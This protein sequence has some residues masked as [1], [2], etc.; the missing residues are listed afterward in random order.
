MFNNLGNMK[1]HTKLHIREAM[2]EQLDFETTVDKPA[3]IYADT[4]G[5]KDIF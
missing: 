1:S 3:V 2:G 5:E 4:T